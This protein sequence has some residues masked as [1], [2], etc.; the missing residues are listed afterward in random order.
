MLHT[1]NDYTER[2]KEQG[3]QKMVQII[4]QNNVSQNIKTQYLEHGWEN[5]V[6]K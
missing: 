2:D 4:P 6:F 3:G 5:D 1:N